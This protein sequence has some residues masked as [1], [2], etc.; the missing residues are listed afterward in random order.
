MSALAQPDFFDLPP[1]E[2]IWPLTFPEKLL[3]LFRAEHP[4]CADVWITPVWAAGELLNFGGDFDKL[5]TA[6]KITRQEGIV[7][8]HLLRLILLCEEFAQHVPEGAVWRLDLLEL[9]DRL[10]ESCRAVDARTTDKMIESAHAVDPLTTS[11]ATTSDDMP[12]P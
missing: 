6:K 5:V 8:R 4:G 3:R 7:F 9:A 12:G 1:E 2:R 10:T 11:S